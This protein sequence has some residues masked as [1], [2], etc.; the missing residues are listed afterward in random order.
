MIDRPWL[1]VSE[2]LGPH[3]SSVLAG[4]R[5][6]ACILGQGVDSALS[7]SIPHPQEPCGMEV[8]RC[9]SLPHQSCSYPTV[10]STAVHPR[11]G[12]FGGP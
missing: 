11:A 3:L 12:L 4:A 1:L 2:T 10:T 7:P 5:L 9:C 8:I 6:Q